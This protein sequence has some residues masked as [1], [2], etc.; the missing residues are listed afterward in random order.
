[1]NID[2]L[3][4]IVAHVLVMA[5]SPSVAV[6][7]LLLATPESWDKFH[8][9]AIIAA[10][11][12]LISAYLLLVIPQVF[13]LVF[14]TPFVFCISRIPMRFFAIVLALILG[15][16]AGWILESN[17]IRGTTADFRIAAVAAG[18]IALVVL[19]EAWRTYAKWKVI[20]E[21]S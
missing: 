17:V 14:L 8:F 19:E 15:A 16:G 9:G 13:A 20:E 11:F 10:L 1:M 4:L 18:S 5:L 7:I 6:A 21:S 12:S 3:R 2:W